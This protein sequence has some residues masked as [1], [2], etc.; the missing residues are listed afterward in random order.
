VDSVWLHSVD[1]AVNLDGL[2]E[3]GTGLRGTQWDVLGWT[4]SGRRIVVRSGFLTRDDA[5]E[6]IAK[7]IARG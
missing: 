6:W 5:L 1:G 7:L 3:L 2:D 4:S